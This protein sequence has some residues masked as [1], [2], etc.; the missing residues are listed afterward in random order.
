[1]FQTEVVE[2]IET[3]ILYSIIVAENYTI[4]RYLC[5]SMIEPGRP[6]MTV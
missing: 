3:H 1:M 6:H 5:N 4:V 2:K